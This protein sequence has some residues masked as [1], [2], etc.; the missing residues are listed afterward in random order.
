MLKLGADSIDEEALSS[1]VTGSLVNC[2]WKR[3]MRSSLTAALTDRLLRRSAYNDTMP[4]DRVHL[5]YLD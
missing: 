5:E 1:I 3:S 2:S 4:R